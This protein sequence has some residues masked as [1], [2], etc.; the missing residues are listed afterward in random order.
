MGQRLL[1]H[2]QVLAVAGD[3][4]HFPEAS[5]E[6]RNHQLAS[7]RIASWTEPT[8]ERLVDDD[9][10]RRRLVVVHREAASLQDRDAHQVEVFRRDGVAPD[11]ELGVVGRRDFP[12]RRHDADVEDVAHRHAERHADRLDGRQRAELALDFVVERRRPRRRVADLVGIDAQRQDVRRSK[13]RS[14]S[15]ARCELRMHRPATI[16]RT[17]E[18]ATCATT[19]PL[20]RRCLPPP[21][22]PMPAVVEEPRDLRPRR[23]QRRHEPHQPPVT[24]AIALAY[25]NTRQ[26]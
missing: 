13:P 7:D 6:P 9:E 4:G 8:R 16:S 25:T 2:R 26:S 19:I 22:E 14:I 12:F 10:M 21:A 23:A 1:E 17:S 3:A 24:P 11:V 20:R 15:C 18:P 5:F